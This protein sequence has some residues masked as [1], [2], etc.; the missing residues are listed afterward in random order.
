MTVCT[1]PYPRSLKLPQ[2]SH[3]TDNY[4]GDYP[5]PPDL[6]DYPHLADV[7]GSAAKVPWLVHG[8]ARDSGC[9]NL[10]CISFFFKICPLILNCQHAAIPSFRV[11]THSSKTLVGA[12]AMM[13]KLAAT[14]PDLPSRLRAMP[15]P[16]VVGD[17][18]TGVGTCSRVISAAMAELRKR[19]PKNCDDHIEAWYASEPIIVQHCNTD[20]VTTILR[21]RL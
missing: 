18:F 12:Q 6:Q 13:R 3:D 9:Y 8:G 16:L 5:D 15:T 4:E 1:V 20:R 11:R 21:C 19:I 14:M 10:Q 17:C 2:E 7:L